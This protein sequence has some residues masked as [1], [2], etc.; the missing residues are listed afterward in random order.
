MKKKLTILVPCFNESKT[1]EKILLKILK[2]KKI[3]KQIIV[4][5]D[6]S[7]D[8]SL[9]K[10]L[11]FRNLIDKIIVHS[12]NMGKGSCIKS[13]QKFI[14]GDIVIIQDADLEYFPSDYKKLIGPIYEKKYKVVYGSRVLG[15][16]KKQIK[17]NFYN[18]D[19]RVIGNFILTKISNLLNKQNLTDAHTCYKVFDAHLFKSL[20]LKQNDFAFCP[21]ITSLISKKKIS[22][23]ELPIKYKGR[24]VR[25][26]KKIK[27]MDAF[28]ALKVLIKL[29]FS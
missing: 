26:G 19:I 8:D 12:K 25:E 1:I 3:N 29:K 2:Q 17:K 10:I 20:R 16:S 23:L 28:K 4:I 14:T 18:P 13:A 6:C 9:K 24:G 15:K 27:F 22:I 11:K 5:D 7:S 21:E